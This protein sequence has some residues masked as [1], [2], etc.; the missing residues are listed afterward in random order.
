MINVSPL[1]IQKSIV[2]PQ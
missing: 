1:R 2:G